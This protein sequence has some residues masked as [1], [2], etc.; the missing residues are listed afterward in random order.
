MRR[1]SLRKTHATDPLRLFVFPVPSRDH[2]NKDRGH[3]TFEHS[4]EEAH[5][6][7]ESKVGGGSVKNEEPVD[8]TQ[9]RQSLHF[10]GRDR[11]GELTLPKERY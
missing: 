7:E 5:S 8:E 1:D 4:Q 6:E 10:D 11:Q 2:G 3:A 9:L